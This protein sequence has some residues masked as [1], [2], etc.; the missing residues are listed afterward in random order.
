VQLHQQ[1]DRPATLSFLEARIQAVPYWLRTILTDNGI[2]SSI[3]HKND[4]ERRLTKLN[5]PWTNG[6]VERINRNIQKATVK[7]YN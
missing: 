2:L 3:W 6:Q 5:D 7:Q 4:I 1:A